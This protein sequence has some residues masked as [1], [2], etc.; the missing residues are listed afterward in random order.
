M[1]RYDRTYSCRSRGS[2]G[3]KI[4]GPV[5]ALPLTDEVYQIYIIK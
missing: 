1:K 4:G 5:K 3:A 2:M